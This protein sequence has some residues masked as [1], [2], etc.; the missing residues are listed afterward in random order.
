MADH[1]TSISPCLSTFQKLAK[2]YM[3]F[4]IVLQNKTSFGVKSIFCKKDLF[5]FIRK[6]EGLITHTAIP[7]KFGGVN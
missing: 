4:W 5:N 6:Y 7:K 1:F 2:D 3:V